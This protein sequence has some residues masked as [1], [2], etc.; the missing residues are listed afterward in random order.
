MPKRISIV[1]IDRCTGCALCSF[2]CARRFG[3]GGLGKSDIFVKSLGG[4]ERGFAVVVCRA[5]KEV[6]PCAKAC[7]VD[8]LESRKGL[9]VTLLKDKCISCGRCVEA[10]PFGAVFWDEEI[11]KP[12]VCVYCGICAKYCP[13][14]VIAWEEIKTGSEVS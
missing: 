13:H 10:C 4:V 12:T 1:D 6:A 11:D 8:A 9:G 5:C 2:A 3:V 7:P 14:G